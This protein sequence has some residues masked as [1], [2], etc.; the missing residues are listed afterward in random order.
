MERSLAKRRKTVKLLRD[1][2]RMIDRTNTGF[3]PRY[4]FMSR[5]LSMRVTLKNDELE[6][7]LERHGVGEN[8][9]YNKALQEIQVKQVGDFEF[10][11]LGEPYIE[12]K[13][14]Q[15]GKQSRNL[16]MSPENAL[17]FTDHKPKLGGTLDLHLSPKETSAQ[18]RALA[19]VLLEEGLTEKQMQLFQKQ[20][21][22]ADKSW[23]G[24]LHKSIFEK[25]LSRLPISDAAKESFIEYV[26]GK[27]AC[28]LLTKVG[29]LLKAMNITLIP[30][31][32]E[33]KNAVI[34]TTDNTM[35]DSSLKMLFA[36]KLREKFYNFAAAFR[37]FD[38]NHDS[39][40]DL[41]EF[42][43][44]IF[45]LG[46]M[47][48]HKER[49]DLFNALDNKKR[50]KID[51]TEFSELLDEPQSPNTSM[52]PRLHKLNLPILESKV[53]STR[54]NESF[55]VNLSSTPKKPRA[56]RSNSVRPFKLRGLRG[57]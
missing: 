14:A 48:A 21:L 5:L 4:D 52:L 16:N 19:K 42:H 34:Q 29:V 26:C 22:R 11:Y 46:L 10:W 35:Q 2:Y 8:V 12:E 32:I 15:E 31:K 36:E 24:M 13:S 51:Y 30:V 57:Y 47:L 23:S 43:K 50:G 20:L 18:A 45:K 3:V 38:E 41:D 37:K 55:E 54:F 7:L 39:F 27:E 44:A 9:D 33:M 25:T 17:A 53:K 56:L 40:I 49:T 1:I 28:A 6:G